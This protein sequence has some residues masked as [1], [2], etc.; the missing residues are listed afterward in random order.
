MNA[1]NVHD[2]NCVLQQTANAYPLSSAFMSGLVGVPFWN[3][4]NLQML[5]IWKQTKNACLWVAYTP[6]L[7]NKNIQTGI[8]DCCVGVGACC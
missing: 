2:W 5:G 7:L 1:A 6:E 3:I 4:L 8:M